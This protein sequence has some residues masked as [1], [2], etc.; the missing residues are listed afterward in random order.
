MEEKSFKSVIHDKFYEY[1]RYVKAFQKN[2]IEDVTSVTK[3]RQMI[4]NLKK[5]DDNLQY[6][7]VKS[8]LKEV[9][10]KDYEVGLKDMDLRSNYLRVLIEYKT[11]SEIFKVDLKLDDITKKFL[12]EIV[13]ANS[14]SLYIVE[15]DMVIARDSDTHSI[16]MDKVRNKFSEDKFLTQVFSMLTESVKTE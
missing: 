11:L 3:D 9:Q 12:D 16:F 13:L 7:D 14:T 5:K 1:L 6:S 2:I 15:K 10:I 4:L 8:I